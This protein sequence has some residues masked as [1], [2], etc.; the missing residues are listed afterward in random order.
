MRCEPVAT[1]SRPRPLQRW[2]VGLVATLSLVIASAPLFS[3][4]LPPLV[5]YPNHLARF[6]LLVSGGNQYFAVR[7]APLPNLAGDL[8]VPALARLVPL[9]A[10]GKLFLVAIF[11]LTLGG[12]AWLNRVASGS[13]RLWPLLAAVFLYNREFLWGFLNYLFGLGCA[14]CGG[15]LW[16]A[17]ENRP[18]WLRVATSGLIALVCFVSHIA[19]FGVYALIVAGIEAAPAVAELR[20]RNWRSPARRAA[21]AG[22]QFVTPAAIVLG[23]WHAADHGGGFSY[24]RFARKPDLLF[25]VF[26]NYNRP[27]DIVCF[28]LLLLLIGGLAWRRRLQVVPRLAPAVGLLVAAFVLLPTQMLSGSGAD[29]RLAPAIFVLL[30]ASAAPRWPS[31][32]AAAC[33]AGTVAVMLGA[34]MVVIEAVWLRADRIYRK[35]L[36]AIDKLPNGAKLAVAFPPDA[37]AAGS[38]PELHVPTLAVWRRQAFVPTL[39]AYPAQQPIAVSP[40]Y[41]ALAAATSGGELWKALHDGGGTARQHTAS[42]LARYDFI[43]FVDRT[44]F[45]VPAQPCLHPFALTPTLQIFAV[46]HRRACAAP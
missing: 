7:W 43:A 22:A 3:T 8:I 5:D 42:T 6:S 17:L 38:I 15:A 20:A 2:R 45:R 26:D 28:V 13:W 11:A 31:R 10:A 39:F 37:V 4:V 33:V 27:F 29:H 41:A 9:A 21:V 16:L 19:A 44:P 46:A 30:V 12:A 32:R 24:G 34:R 23:W 35:D 1:A 25:S 18:T 36:A 14:L 40:P